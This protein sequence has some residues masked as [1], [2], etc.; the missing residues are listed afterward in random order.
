MMAA[1]GYHGPEVTYT[2][3]GA[4]DFHSTHVLTRQEAAALYYQILMVPSDLIVA[5]MTAQ[6]QEQIPPVEEQTPA[7]QESPSDEDH[8]A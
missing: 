6:A 8:A 3:D 4:V 7:Q 1:L 5:E 2:E